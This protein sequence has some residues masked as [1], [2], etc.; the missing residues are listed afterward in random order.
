MFGVVS[1][2]ELEVLAIL[3]GGAKSFH[4]LKVGGGARKRLPCL[5]GGRHER[6]RT[7]DFPFL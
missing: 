5:K 4:H 1:T 7:D 6:F 3:K 2:Q